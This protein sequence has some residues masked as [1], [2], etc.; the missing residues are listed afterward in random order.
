MSF[1]ANPV[2]FFLL[3]EI[4]HDLNF[5]SP[6]VLTALVTTL[7]PQNSC[8]KRYVLGFIFVLNERVVKNEEPIHTYPE[9]QDSGVRVYH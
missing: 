3:I 1:L 7:T 5:K 6:V 9:S 4:I 8:L 2:F